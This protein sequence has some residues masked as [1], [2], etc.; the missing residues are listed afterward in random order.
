MLT[1]KEIALIREELS[2]AKNPLFLYDSD[3]DYWLPF[4]CF[5]ASIARVRE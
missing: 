2:T 4:F 5:T 3:A 1:N